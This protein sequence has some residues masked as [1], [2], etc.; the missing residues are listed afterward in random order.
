MFQFAPNYQKRLFYEPNGTKSIEFPKGNLFS[1]IDLLLKLEVNIATGGASNAPD[2]HV[3]NAI[4]NISLIKNSNINVWSISGQAMAALYTYDR[5]SG[6]AAEN[7]A[8]VAGS[9]A[10][11]V[12]GQHFLNVP[13]YPLDAVN[14]KDFACDTR[15]NDYELK[16]KWKD[17]TAVGTLFGTHTGAI[18]AT[19]TENYLDIELKMLELRP[20]PINGQPD[21]LSEVPPMI[22]GLREERLDVDSSNTKFEVDIV[23]GIDFRNIIL[24]TTHLAN[25]G[26]EVGENDIIQNFM[27]LRDSKNQTM[28]Y[29]SVEMIRELTSQKWGLGSSLPNGIYDVPLTAYGHATDVVRSTPVKDLIMNLDVVKQTNDTKIRPIFVSQE[30]QD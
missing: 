30:R 21:A 24:Y 18:T 12:Q 25:T 9:A 10:S 13:F 4:D 5:E 29:R 27:R 22:V 3:F 16:I 1:A 15:F 6:V 11:N 26:Q 14:K 19:N 8:A 20:N 17:L 23:D 7:N 2:F 28:Q